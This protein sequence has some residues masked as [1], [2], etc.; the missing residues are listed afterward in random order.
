MGKGDIQT[1]KQTMCQIGRKTIWQIGRETSIQ[2]KKS[3]KKS[4]KMNGKGKE[5][6]PKSLRRHRERERDGERD[7]EME[8]KT[9]R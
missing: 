7:R 9:D 8:K 4:E 1:D 2:K 6:E 3:L 5:I